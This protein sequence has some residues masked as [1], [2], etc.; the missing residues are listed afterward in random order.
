M[1]HVDATSQSATVTP[2]LQR[3]WSL[4]SHCRNYRHTM[5]PGIPPRLD[6]PGNV[7]LCG[8]KSP[9]G[10]DNTRFNLK[11][12]QFKLQSEVSPIF[13]VCW[14]T[15]TGLDRL[16]VEWRYNR[17][18]NLA[19]LRVTAKLACLFRLVGHRSA[20]HLQRL[21]F[22]SNVGVTTPRDQTCLIPRYFGEVCS[23]VPNSILLRGSPTPT[24][25]STSSRPGSL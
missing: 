15:K 17:R 19:V 3:T 8:C 12:A 9:P 13:Q 10:E 22:E 1:A 14:A 21:Q 6:S 18:P 24:T 2:W 5:D 4:C 20:E 23:G 25:P 7:S 11:L 16:V